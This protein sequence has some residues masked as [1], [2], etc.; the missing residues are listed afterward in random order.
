M[1]NMHN[2][3]W[4]VISL[5][6]A[7]AVAV[8]A[9]WR[10]WRSRRIPNWITVPALLAGVGVNTMAW[11]WPGTK[12]ALEGAGLALGILLPF[13]L[14]RGMGAGDWKLMGALGAFLG[15]GKLVLVL[16][17]TIFIAGIM[18]GVEMVLRRRVRETLS[19]LWTLL[20]IIMTFGYRGVRDS[21][22][23]ISLDNPKLM[24]VPFGVS[25]AISMVVFAG[26]QSMVMF[27]WGG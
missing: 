16:L 2:V 13:V 6:L 1:G 3:A 15:P 21:R 17:G 4:S 19:N 5:S 9:G 11:G 27:V 22:D 8:W 7:M 25:A 12:A 23:E 14:A 20:L 24:A 26:W 10:D 18:A